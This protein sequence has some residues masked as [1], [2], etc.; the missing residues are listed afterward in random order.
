MEE[1]K[2]H[3]RIALDEIHATPTDGIYVTKTD[4]HRLVF[5]GTAFCILMGILSIFHRKK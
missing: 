5:L 1:L 3:Y 4:A 2:K